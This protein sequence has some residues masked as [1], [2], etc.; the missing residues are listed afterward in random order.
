M[1]SLLNK[2]SV[3][4]FTPDSQG[5]R[6]VT[7]NQKQMD[8]ANFSSYDV[9]RYLIDEVIWIHNAARQIVFVS[10]SIEHVLG[11]S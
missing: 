1:T 2:E 11:Y 4:L 7:L 6:S 3:Y 10:P 8:N 5:W 9:M